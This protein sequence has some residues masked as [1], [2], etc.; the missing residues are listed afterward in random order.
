M[1]D[2][3]MRRIDE[4]LDRQA[5]LLQDLEQLASK[6]RELIERMIGH[7]EPSQSAGP[8]GA[9]ALTMRPAR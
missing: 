5:V 4:L 6:Q 1:I 7:V 2:D 3:Q 8:A 9:G